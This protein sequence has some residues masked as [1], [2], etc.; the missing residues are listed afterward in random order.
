MIEIALAQV[1][2]AHTVAECAISNRITSIALARD[3]GVSWAAI[4]EALGM[5]R[6]TAQKRFGPFLDEPNQA[7]AEATARLVDLAVGDGEP[8]PGGVPGP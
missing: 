2:M 1:K 4:G 7:V 6:Q 8:E 3:M 5:S